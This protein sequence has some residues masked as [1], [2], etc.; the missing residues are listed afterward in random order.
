MELRTLYYFLAVVREQSISAAA[1][2]LLVFCLLYTP[3]V[4]AVASIKREL[5]GKWAMVVVVGQCVIAWLVSWIVYLFMG[6][7]G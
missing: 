2:S 5:S 6:W 7:L 4:A 3:C 1:A